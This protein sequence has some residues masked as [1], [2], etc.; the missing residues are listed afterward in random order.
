[1][2]EQTAK[3]TST[4]TMNNKKNNISPKNCTQTV[5]DSCGTL[6]AIAFNG[7]NINC[8]SFSALLCERAS[9]VIMLT[10]LLK[11]GQSIEAVIAI[12]QFVSFQHPNYVV[13]ISILFDLFVHFFPSFLT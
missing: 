9:V 2:N 8:R 5:D 10:C 4:T 1:M 7:T 12:I 3:I 6:V 11:N 13:V